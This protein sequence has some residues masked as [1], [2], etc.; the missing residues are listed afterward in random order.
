M[1]RRLE[2]YLDETGERGAASSRAHP[3]QAGIPD[4]KAQR[5]HLKLQAE[6]LVEQH[7]LTPPLAMDELRRLGEHACEMAGLERECADYAAVL[8][9][10]AAWREIVAGIP[11]EKRL[12]M[13]PQCLR[14]DSRC[15][16]SIDEFGLVCEG[17]GR[18]SIHA[19]Q[20]E[21]EALGYAVLVAEGSALVTN[22]IETGQIQAVVGISCMSVLEKCHPHMEARAV[23]GMAVPLLYDGC[24]NTAVDL[25]WAR[26]AIYATSEDQT[27]RLNLEMLKRDVRSWFELESLNTLLGSA[28][29]ET[30]KIAR[31]WL[32]RDGKRWRPYLTAC[33][34]MSLL[35]DQGGESPVISI[36]LKKLAVAVECFH[37]AS[38]VHD[39]IEDDDDERYG[40]KALHIEHGMPVALNAG[41]FLLGEGYRIIGELGVEAD[42]TAALFRIAAAGHLTLSRGQGA[43]LCWTRSPGPLTPGEVLDIF[44]QKTSPAF[45]VAMR[46]GAEL[47][48]AEGGVHDT[49]RAYSEALGT[50]YQIRDDL[51]DFLGE[52]DSD[53]LRDRRP[54]IVL[55]AAHQ[56]VSTD[57]ERRS[58]ESMWGGPP[59]DER[60]VE[61]VRRLLKKHVVVE[62]VSHLLDQAV[63]QAVQT[64][65]P[66]KQ[67]SLKGLLR[68]VIGKIFGDVRIEDYCKRLASRDSSSA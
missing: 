54:S 9:S 8:I 41:D 42:V 14:D 40:Q 3:T 62:S 67:P 28:D 20:S 47:A 39:D 36:D 44:R 46:L 25:D 16:A 24:R 66:L 55:A 57:A 65:Q 52:G 53:D 48:R 30:E 10:N 45:E 33:V 61:E 32:A 38:L 50:A 7:D 59:G 2:S 17:C 56:R 4:A 37:K 26:E 11:Y 68:R 18:C 49:L 34:Y 58:I 21:A 13:L 51:E 35:Y 12:L 31:D 1:M 43:E 23:P 60:T 22:L 15:P 27:R 6:A 63:A 5:E 29:G 64:L 19:L